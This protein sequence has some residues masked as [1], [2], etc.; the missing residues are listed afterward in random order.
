[1]AGSYSLH[2]GGLWKY[3]FI[4]GV[5]SIPF[6][7]VVHVKTGSGIEF[8]SVTMVLGGGVAGYL[9]K[10]DSVRPRMAG[11]LAGAIGALPLLWWWSTVFGTIPFGVMPVWPDAIQRFV[12]LSVLGLIVFVVA[13]FAGWLGGQAGRWISE[14][15]HRESTLDTG[16]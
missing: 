13:V 16:S 10:R 12:Y 14:R 2:W 6:T 4:G 5:I 11:A 7:V 1:M 15:I 3:A 8:S 9:T